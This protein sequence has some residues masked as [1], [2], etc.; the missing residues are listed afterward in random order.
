M[1]NSKYWQKFASSS[2]EP[3]VMSAIFYLD[4][5]DDSTLYPPGGNF[6]D[7]KER[8]RFEK[9][10]GFSLGSLGLSKYCNKTTVYLHLVGSK[11]D[12]R[13]NV[14]EIFVEMCPNIK[15]IISPTSIYTPTRSSKLYFSWENVNQNDADTF[16]EFVSTLGPC[17]KKELDIF[18]EMVMIFFNNN[19]D[20]NLN[21]CVICM[22]NP[23]NA[24]F[25]HGDSGHTICCM[26]CA[27]NLEKCPLCRKPIEKVIKNFC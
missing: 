27:K 14:Y 8:K 16:L 10:C 13:E 19:L 7:S 3:V 18:Y 5:F 4:V 15:D 6:K 17:S 1:N 21:E 25:V 24:T 2:S 20:N 26:D 22:D 12:P 9:S 11:G 23:N